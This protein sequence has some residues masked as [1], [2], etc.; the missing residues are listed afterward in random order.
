MRPFRTAMLQG[1]KAQMEF[2]MVQVFLKDMFEVN[3]VGALFDNIIPRLPHGN[4]GLIFTLDK[5]PYYPGTCQYIVKWKPKSQNTVDFKVQNIA[6]NEHKLIGL[7]TMDNNQLVLFDLV[8]FKS[9][10]E[11]ATYL[12][13]IVEMRFDEKHTTPGLMSY[14]MIKEDKP[15][16]PIDKL[17][18]LYDPNLF[19]KLAPEEKMGGG[20]VPDRIRTER[21]EPNANKTAK[22]VL[23]SIND[24]VS[25]EDLADVCEGIQAGGMLGKRKRSGDEE[26]ELDDGDMF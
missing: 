4:D 22:N 11:Q 26:E 6:G 8:F 9:E 2:P 25:K 14:N 20:W 3:A 17:V 18:K 13:K 19:K 12:N 10:E 5:C 21:Q 7:Y 1:T 23:V 16:E 15:D 24:S